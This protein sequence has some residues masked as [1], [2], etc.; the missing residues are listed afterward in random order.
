MGHLTPPLGLDPFRPETVAD[1]PFGQHRAAADDVQERLVHGEAGAMLGAVVMVEVAVHGNPARLREGD[2]LPDL[3][4]LEVALLQQGQ[5]I[6]AGG[7]SAAERR[8]PREMRRSGPSD[9]RVVRTMRRL[10]AGGGAD[11]AVGAEPAGP[12]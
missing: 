3:A 7:G 5:P 6:C 9:G 2:R 8:I 4:P 10:L 1:A 11:R 12:G